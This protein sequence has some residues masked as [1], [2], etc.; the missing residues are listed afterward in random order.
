MQCVHSHFTETGIG[1]CRAATGRLQRPGVFKGATPS[2]ETY[3]S[4][5]DPDAR[6]YRKGK[7]ASE[8]CRVRHTLSDNRYGLVVNPRVA[9]A[10]SHPEQN[11]LIKYFHHI[12]AES[13][14]AHARR[15]ISC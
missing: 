13:A 15:H 2:K 3:P 12:L 8:L 1:T 7:S 5:V 9:H 6:P 10:N 4:Q 14:D 11:R